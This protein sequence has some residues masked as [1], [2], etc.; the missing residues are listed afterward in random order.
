M[1]KLN[2]IGIGGATTIELGGNCC[3]IKN[4]NDLLIIDAC[5]EATKKLFDVEAFNDI[6]DI[7][8]ILTHTHYDHVAG[9]GVLLWYSNFY[10]NKK[11]KIIYND[12]DY[13]ERISELLRITGV[14][15]K[16]YDFVHENTLNFDFKVNMQQTPHALDMKCF[17]IMFEDD[18]GKY[19]YTGDTRDIDYVRKLAFDDNVKTIY[20]EVA[21]ETYDVHI[22]YEDIMDLDKDKFILMHFDTLRLYERIIKDGFKTASIVGPEKNIVKQI[23]R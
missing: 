1:E 19:Y 18:D 6:N 7:Y 11:P 20:C 22:K 15:E 13:K 5:E 4:N 16:F 8:I 12:E 3:Y 23:K 17:G 21:E 9:L 2:F 10:L 14:N